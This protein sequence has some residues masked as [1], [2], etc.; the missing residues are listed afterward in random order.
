VIPA[1]YRLLPVLAL[2][3]ALWGVLW[4]GLA[5]PVA[6][7]TGPAEASSRLPSWAVPALRLVSS[8]H[9]EPTTGVVLSDTGLVLVPL[10]FGDAGDE[11]IVLDGGTDIVRNGRPARLERTFPELGLKV[12]SVA[13][14]KRR[15][16]SL[17]AEPLAAGSTV[18]LA[19][20]P[21]AER[22]EEGAPPLL[23]PVVLQAAPDGD[24]LSA[25]PALPN[26]TG[27]LLDACG[28]LAGYSVADGVQTVAPAAGTHYRWQSA[29]QAVLGDL[30]L[31]SAG[32]P[33]TAADA[34]N[35]DSAQEA[36]AA[37]QES[38][39][40]LP[41]GADD[42]GTEPPAEPV[43]PAAQ[44]DAE[45]P[46]DVLPPLESGEAPAARSPG[47]AADDGIPAA[48]WLGA[49]LLLIV[50]G[51]AVHRIRTRSAAERVGAPSANLSDDASLAGQHPAGEHSVAGGDET[52]WDGR[53]VLRGQYADGRALLAAAPVNAR[54]INLEIGRGNADLAL[55]SGAVS[56]R[57]ARLG[58]SAAALTL[59]DLGSSNGS[60][61]NG[62]PCLEGEVMFVGPGDTVI[63]GDV[64]FVVEFEPAAKAD[65]EAGAAP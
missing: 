42:P 26:V 6:A 3:G 37:A 47:P 62:V 48:G 15:G 46:P 45:S 10:A 1:P 56:R 50:A 54:A 25:E 22:I 4:S 63:L 5:L 59:A 11:I 7:Q 14:L 33:C 29:L 13:G 41:P 64:R 27:A 18:T 43:A 32:L 21:P 9:V 38:D 36:P 16:A 28:R 35:A 60:S 2:A 44:P 51:L 20:F 23:E 53:L 19:A 8:T 17:S 57:H 61:I 58:G 31:A 12:L 65:D 24:G 49:A 40:R 55:D 30:G 34:P 52:P 39:D